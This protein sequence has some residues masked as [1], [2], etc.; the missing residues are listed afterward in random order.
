M[1]SGL[2]AL[3]L[4]ADPTLSPDD[5]KCR[6]MMSSQGYVM[7]NLQGQGTG[8]VD[9]LGL[10]ASRASGCANQGLDLAADLGRTQ[11]FI[12]PFRELSPASLVA[13]SNSL[14]M[15]NL[16][17]AVDPT[18]LARSLYVDM[19]AMQSLG[20]DWSKEDLKDRGYWVD[21]AKFPSPQAFSADAPLEGKALAGL[22]SKL[23]PVTGFEGTALDPVRLS[24]FIWNL[25]APE[26]AGFIWNLSAAESAGFI[27]NLSAPESAGFI[28]NLSAPGSAG[29][30]WNLS[31][32]ESA[33]FIWNL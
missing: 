5:L 21:R 27:W 19:D 6:L 22:M 7:G 3:A 31:A 15:F 9:G 24:G 26:S 28:W 1:V 32:P 12:G 16:A 29:F 8:L 14:G 25:S 17:T 23:L 33:G 20:F 30:I 4:Q 13:E 10:L 11:R 2:A 18:A